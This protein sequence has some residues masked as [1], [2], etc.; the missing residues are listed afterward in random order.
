MPLLEVLGLKK[1]P[2]GLPA[3]GKAARQA[4]AKPA[5]SNGSAAPPPADDAKAEAARADTASQKRFEA[6]ARRVDAQLAKAKID[7]EA[8][9][10]A[11]LKV[12]LQAELAALEQSHRA[13]E[14]AEPTSVSAKLMEQLDSPASNFA[15]RVATMKKEGADGLREVNDWGTKPL[16]D[17]APKIAALPAGWKRTFEP[18]YKTLQKRLAD[19]NALLDK[20]DF[21]ALSTAAG[22]LFYACGDLD[23]ALDEYA[24]E[25][26]LFAAERKKV[27]AMLDRMKAGGMLDADGA[28][29][30]ADLEAALGR[31]D[32]LGPIRGYKSA[33]ASLNGVVTQAKAVRDT[34]AAYKDYAPERA[35]VAALVAALKSH[36]Q[37]GRLGAEIKQIEGRLKTAD[38]LSKRADGGSLKALTALK[39]ITVQCDEARVLATKLAAAE[40]KLPALTRKLT[41]SGVPKA[42]IEQTARF[43]LKALVEENCSDDEAVKMARDASGYADE[44]LEEQDAIMSSRVKKSLEDGGLAPE[45]AKAIGKNIRAGGTSS[46]DDAKAVAKSM[47]HI[48]RKAIE[49]LTAN[50]ITTECCRGPITDALPGLAGVKPRGWPETSSWDDVPG[51]YSGDNKKLVVGTRAAD[52]GKREVPATGQGPLPHGASDLLGHEAGH[53]F[54]AA[55]GGGKK[56]NAKFLAARSADIAAGPPSGMIPGTDSYFLTAAEGGANDSGATSETFAES[57]AMHFSGKSRWPKLEEFWK[58]NPWGI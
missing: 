2:G 7:V 1:P 27:Q 40:K 28:K 24:T 11:A 22:Q 36:P 25:Y 52:D 49:T 26:P 5:G 15:S 41:D 30:M 16:A 14:I 20:G 37:A 54:D 13:A 39:A 55:D 32:A 12:Q 18:R 38:D 44:G 51:V 50:K 45:H 23:T 58:A 3:S 48:S 31:A 34:N 46:A 57:F 6:F 53:A 21:D 9:P 56:A 42:K 43:A 19:A 35:R 47:S 17:L 33:R 29:S 4:Q 10:V 8:Q